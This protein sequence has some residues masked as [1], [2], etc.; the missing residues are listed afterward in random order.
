MASVGG[1]ESGA[2]VLARAYARLLA[3]DKTSSREAVAAF[4]SGRDRSGDSALSS[5]ELGATPEV[6]ARFDANAD[7]LVDRSEVLRGFS[8]ESR[9]GSPAAMIERIVAN[10]DVDGDSALSEAELSLGAA[11]FA[12]MDADADG[13]VSRLELRRALGEAIRLEEELERA[14]SAG[15]ANAGQPQTTPGGGASGAAAARVDLKARAKLAY[16]YDDADPTELGSMAA[17]AQLLESLRQSG[18]E[19]VEDAKATARISVYG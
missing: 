13:V 8:I 5:E 7:G 6:F 10:R 19:L 15:S 3:I 16:R 17:R 11:G 1:L 9:E 2:S 4:V 12:R 14:R 18:E